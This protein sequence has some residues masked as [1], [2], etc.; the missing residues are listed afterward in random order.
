MRIKNIS[1]KEL[2]DAFSDNQIITG[3]ESIEKNDEALVT[4]NELNHS[5]KYKEK[6][7]LLKEIQNASNFN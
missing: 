3:T 1:R 5:K 4:I 7:I 6:Y 2:A